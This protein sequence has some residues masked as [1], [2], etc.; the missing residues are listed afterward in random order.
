MQ[1]A[2][3]NII[4]QEIAKNLFYYRKKRKMTQKQL[5]DHLGVRHN[6]VSSWENGINSIDVETLIRA[7]QVLEISLGEVYGQ[8]GGSGQDYTQKE[9]SL[10]TQYRAH[11][12]LQP[13]VDILLGLKE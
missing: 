1:E 2:E 12:E 11:P 7:C 8:F 13:A 4:K 10:V 9:K 6:S 3:K 5:A